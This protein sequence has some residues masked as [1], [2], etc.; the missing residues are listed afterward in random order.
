MRVLFTISIFFTWNVWAKTAGSPDVVYGV[1]NRAEVYASS[2]AHQKLADSTAAMIHKSIMTNPI[3][4]LLNVNPLSWGLEKEFKAT[5][6]T[7]TKFINQQ[8]HSNCS[9]SL[10]APDLILTAGHCYQ[11]ATSCADFNWVFNYKLNSSGQLPLNLDKKNV[12]SC[13][14]VLSSF[15][16]T[17]SDLDYAI[18]QLDRKVEGRSPLKYRLSDKVENT[19]NFFT[20]GTPKGLPLKV[21]TDGKMRDNYPTN[22]FITSL[23]T[24]SGNSGSPVFNTA[25]NVIEGILVRGDADYVVDPT[26]KCV[27]EKK[28]SE[29][30]CTGE[31][32]S[33]VL[34]VP[35]LATLGKVGDLISKGSLAEIEAIIPKD[36]WVDFPHYNSK[37]LLM[38]AVQYQQPEIVEYLINKGAKL[39]LKDQDGLTIFHYYALQAPNENMMYLINTDQAN[40]EIKNLAGETP[41]L[42][43]ARLKNFEV[44]KILFEAGAKSEAQDNQ[45]NYV[46]KYF[47]DSPEQLKELRYLGLWDPTWVP[48][49]TKW[50]IIGKLFSLGTVPSA[51]KLAA[52]GLLKGRCFDPRN[53]DDAYA[54]IYIV[55]K[56]ESGNYLGTFLRTS[57]EPQNYYDDKTLEDIYKLDPDLY[58]ERLNVSSEGFGLPGEGWYSS[59]TAVGSYLIESFDYGDK[60][61]RCYYFMIDGMDTI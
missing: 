10:I 36:F 42:M 51:E 23:D 25:T 49:V 14:K 59:L 11:K 30:S 41:I 28:C 17:N 19:A 52:K 60:P 4:N 16:T 32:V 22:F 61:T 5:A 35:E 1:D 7:E 53:P 37:T 46:T 20:I 18:I 45:G 56:S 50:D 27:I 12:Y 9:G 44:V 8:F 39:D 2:A 31:S 43:A 29:T 47:A 58:L 38:M 15:L 21:T 33:R 48:T 26:K 13:K 3:Q 57:E 24:F 54:S 40:F 6:C 34:S 55:Q